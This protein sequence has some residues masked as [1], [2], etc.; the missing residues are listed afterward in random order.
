MAN[1]VNENESLGH[2]RTN[3]VNLRD[4]YHYND[5]IL[6]LI[7]L[8]KNYKGLHHQGS[9]VLERCSAQHH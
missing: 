8:V 1:I 2:D 7:D 9:A 3:H 4:L 5:P 6:Q